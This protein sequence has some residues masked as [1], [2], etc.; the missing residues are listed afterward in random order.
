MIK[1]WDEGVA[2]MREGGKRLL[3]IPPDKAYGD[4]GVGDKIPPNAALVFEV[5]SFGI[6]YY[7]GAPVTQPGGQ[8]Q[9]IPPPATAP[10]Q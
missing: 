4:K 2:G 8:P 1:G 3:I 6:G 9:M 10:K 7:P 5:D